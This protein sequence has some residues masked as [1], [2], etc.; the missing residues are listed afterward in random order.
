MKEIQNSL[1]KSIMLLD[2]NS[3]GNAWL[4][5]AILILMLIFTT[6]TYTTTVKKCI[7]GN[8]ASFCMENI[9]SKFNISECV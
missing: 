8:I 5:F 2:C 1:I 9:K 6:T 7:S 3:K 4:T